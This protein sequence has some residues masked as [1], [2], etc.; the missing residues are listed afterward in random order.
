MD[1]L[2]LLKTIF[3]GHAH[4][5]EVSGAR[6]QQDADTDETLGYEL[7]SAV[8][9]EYDAA[10]GRGSHQCRSRLKPPSLL[11][12]RAMDSNTL[13]SALLAAVPREY[14]SRG[15]IVCDLINS[16]WL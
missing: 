12:Q 10:C 15:I 11:A 1:N 7:H 8:G 5:S 4:H 13:A 14:T 9:G 6:Q 2:D 3:T 16:A